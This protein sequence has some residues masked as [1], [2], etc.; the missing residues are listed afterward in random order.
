[1]EDRARL[2][3]A[4]TKHKVRF[5]AAWQELK[6]ASLTAG[7]QDPYH[8]LQSIATLE[9]G[10][11]HP[12]HVLLLSPPLAP[13]VETWQVLLGASRRLG[14]L[15]HHWQMPEG[16][17]QT[18]ALPP[19]QERL[20]SGT[21]SNPQSASIAQAEDFQEERNTKAG[22]RFLFGKKKQAKEAQQAAIRAEA[23]R[24]SLSQQLSLRTA[25]QT[26]KF[27]EE[28]PAGKVDLAMADLQSWVESLWFQALPKRV[29]ERDIGWQVLDQRGTGQEEK[30]AEQAPP[31]PPWTLVEYTL[32]P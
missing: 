5:L 12:H 7:A 9:T 2:V 1:V 26:V 25:G 14:L 16:E 4:P 10:T 19:W 28:N 22:F 11:G 8:L 18:F 32:E 30:D 15:F 17:N 27:S 13:D 31:P 23:A 24:E 3:L 6:P 29:S 21:Q 20:D